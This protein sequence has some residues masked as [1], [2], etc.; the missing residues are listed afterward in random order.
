MQSEMDKT[1]WPGDWAP[2]SWKS[3]PAAQQPAYPEPER[4]QNVL[5]HL[6]KLTRLTQLNLEG[7]RVSDTGLK[8]LQGLP[9]LASVNL[10]RTKVTGSGVRA[11]QEARPGIQVTR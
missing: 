6:A 8:S 5:K 4:L 7:T 9:R 1:A 2:A 10:R 11:L 3:R